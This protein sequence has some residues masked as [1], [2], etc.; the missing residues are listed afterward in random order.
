MKCNQPHT[1]FELRSQI[2]FLLITVT[3]CIFPKVTYDTIKINNIN[4]KNPV[5]MVHLHMHTWL[6]G[7]RCQV[8]YLSKLPIGGCE[9]KPWFSFPKLCKKQKVA[10]ANYTQAM[11]SRMRIVYSKV[12][13]DIQKDQW[14]KHCEYSNQDKNCRL[15]CVKNIN[16]FRS[17][18]KKHGIIFYWVI[19]VYLPL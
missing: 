11:D 17:F 18:Y 1:E 7:L 6:R 8:K 3:H 10:D 2:S 13:E 14:Q 16:K 12:L 19:N 9:F 5:W 4:P 15:Q